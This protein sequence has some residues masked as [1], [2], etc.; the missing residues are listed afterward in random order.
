MNF[1]EWLDKNESLAN[2]VG[3]V[4]SMYTGLPGADELGM[5]SS[6]DNVVSMGRALPG[7]M[8]S[9]FDVGF[10]SFEKKMASSGLD[11][12]SRSNLIGKCIDVKSSERVSS[13]A[14]L[15]VNGWNKA[16]ACNIGKCKP[17]ML[18]NSRGKKYSKWECGS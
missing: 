11:P 15:C 5:Q 12:L 7:Y 14:K 4:A 6:L 18:R 2:I 1:K 3:N 9:A 13:C 17:K 8:K 10:D 16:N